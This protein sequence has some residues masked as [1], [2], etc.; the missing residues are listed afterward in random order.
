MKYLKILHS[1]IVA[2]VILAACATSAP[3]ASAVGAVAIVRGHDIPLSLIRLEDA[4]RRVNVTI[5]SVNGETKW[6]PWGGY[7]SE[8]LLDPGTYDLTLICFGELDNQPFEH[9]VNLSLKAEAGTIYQLEPR[10][11][12]D[13][14]GISVQG[15]SEKR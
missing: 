11:H 14:C 2:A 15:I 10:V 7:A 1:N 4:G 13:G 12:A 5:M 9:Q 3:P 8:V 6:A